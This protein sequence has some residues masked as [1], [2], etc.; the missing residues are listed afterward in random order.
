MCL[1]QLGSKDGR[2]KCS[3]GGGWRC[4]EMASPGTSFCP[5]HQHRAYKKKKKT[6]P[7]KDI[8]VRKNSNKNYTRGKW[9]N[10]P[11]DNGRPNIEED[12]K[13]IKAKNCGR[14]GRKKSNQGD[15]KGISNGKDINIDSQPED[16]FGQSE[17]DDCVMPLEEGT[18]GNLNEYQE[19]SKQQSSI[20]Y[21]SINPSIIEYICL[22]VPCIL[23]F[24][25]HEI[26]FSC[27][28]E[29]S[30]IFYMF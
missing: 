27:K 14:N 20:K 23:H 3:G 22:K 8:H 15:T 19:Y 26:G 4:K 17:D 28:L 2:C 12:L 13:V 9:V 7:A 6:L 29:I 24:L 10:F 21:D 30:L 11:K 18:N 25:L 16:L 5:R 1:L